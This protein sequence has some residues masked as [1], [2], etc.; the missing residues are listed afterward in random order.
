MRGLENRMNAWV[1]L[2]KRSAAAQLQTLL[3]GHWVSRKRGLKIDLAL[4][5]PPKR[6]QA[7]IPRSEANDS[8]SS[9]AFPRTS[10]AGATAR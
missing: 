1:S 2:P 8:I 5:Q 10:V 7:Q 4:T 6:D 3:R 9:W